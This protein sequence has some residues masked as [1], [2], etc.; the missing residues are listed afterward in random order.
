MPTTMK[1][2]LLPLLAACLSGQA[3]VR[4]VETP[5]AAPTKR[6]VLVH[7][8][9]ENGSAFRTMKRRLEKQGYQCL[10]PKLRPSDGRGGLEPLAESLKRDID[11]AY[12]HKAPFAIVA[13]SMG[14]IVSRHYL[15]HLGGSTRCRKFFTISSPH[16]GTTAAWLYPTKG[17]AQMRPGSE[18]LARLNATDHR[19]G[20][21]PVVSYRTPL[22]LIILP[23]SSSVWDRAENIS[24][25]VLLHPLM[26]SSRTVI[27]DIER[28]LAE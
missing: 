8:F 26:V 13:F 15:Q 1:S 3:D 7:G 23:A 9:L 14:G 25:P 22:D 28:R 21:I 5:P 24:H 12:G 18:F 17:A 19:L 2:R 27:R 11:D 10:V 6:V 20:S 16:Q 4:A